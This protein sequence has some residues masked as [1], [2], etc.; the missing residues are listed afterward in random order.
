VLIRCKTGGEMIEVAEGQDPHTALDATGC[1]HCKDG[2]GPDVHCGQA[3][4]ACHQARVDGHPL[5][6]GPCWNPPPG[7]APVPDRPDGCTVC[8]PIVF[9]G[10]TD[11]VTLAG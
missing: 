10:N 8:R 7:H 1:T 6:D 9:A 3:A 11:L 5:H 4:L 2:H